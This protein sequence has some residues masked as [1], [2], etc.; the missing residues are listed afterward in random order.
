[1]RFMLHVFGH[2]RDCCLIWLF[3]CYGWCCIIYG[4]W[5][6]LKGRD[7][8]ML[9]QL[10]GRVTKVMMLSQLYGWVTKVARLRAKVGMLLMN[11]GPIFFSLWPTNFFVWVIGRRL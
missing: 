3:I 10:Y 9:S 8:M 2:W 4:W 5:H 6:K 1:M 11:Y 7:V